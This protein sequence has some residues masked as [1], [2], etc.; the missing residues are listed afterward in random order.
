LISFVYPGRRHAGF[1][2]GAI[3]AVA[4]AAGQVAV[5]NALA[6]AAVTGPQWSVQPTPNA[7]IANGSLAADDCTGPASC[8]AVG[9]YESRLG[10]SALAEAWNGTAWHI[11]AVPVPPGGTHSALD[12]VSCAP[13]SPGGRPP[14]T[15]R[16]PKGPHDSVTGILAATACIAVGYYTSS[17]GVKVTLAER[18]NGTSW[19]VQPTPDP[20]GAK[21]SVLSGVSC[22]SA[23]S[24]MAVGR[25]YYGRNRLARLVEQW[26]GTGWS[27]KQASNPRKATLSALS[28]VSCA[29]ATACVAVGNYLDYSTD[30]WLT[31]AEAWNGGA[32]TV[33]PTP[34]PANSIVNNLF[35]VSCASATACTAV[36]DWIVNGS[37][38]SRLLARTLAEAW[39]GTTWVIEASPS[40]VRI[41]GGIDTLAS[42]SCQSPTSCSAVGTYNVYRG[43][44]TLNEAWNGTAWVIQPTP[45][46]SRH[47]S[48]LAGVSC[49]AAGCTAVGN[50]RDQVGT[51][52]TLAVSSGGGAWAVQATPS[53]VG[54]V[55]SSLASVSCGAPTACTPSGTST[56]A[57][58]TA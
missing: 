57:T 46:P 21:D 29:T 53:P 58:S 28:G 51:H 36:G 6:G 52:L 22:G 25:T 33:T 39:N 32:W 34:N 19:S 43:V 54:A 40:P 56:T 27:I 8:V 15:P 48:Y 3:A 44:K 11:Q 10:K 42:V 23:T 41:D 49:A 17:Q 13:A 50:Y 18:W 31:L 24:C 20:A 35:G 30:D 14:G 16:W 55:P 7:V 5:P 26:N 2:A 47:D 38:P 1:A 12:G 9:S 4:L 37:T 45:N